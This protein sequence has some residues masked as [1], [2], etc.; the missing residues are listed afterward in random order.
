MKSSDIELLVEV[1]TDLEVPGTGGV[2]LVDGAR[3]DGVHQLAQDH[4]VL[5]GVVV[6]HSWRDGGDETRKNVRASAKGAS[7][8]G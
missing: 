7:D 4:A 8:D 3:R 6:R 1:F 5:E 2:D